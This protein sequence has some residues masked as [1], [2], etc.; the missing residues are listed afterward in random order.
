MIETVTMIGT[1]EIEVEN[2]KMGSA[3]LT[4]YRSLYTLVYRI[5]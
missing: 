1:W 5:C 2:N 4:C 3:S